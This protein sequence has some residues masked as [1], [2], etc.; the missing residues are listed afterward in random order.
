MTKLTKKDMEKV[1]KECDNPMEEAVILLMFSSGLCP[2]EIVKLK[3]S[4]FTNSITEYLMQDIME[5]QIIGTWHIQSSNTCLEYHVLNSPESSRAIFKYLNLRKPNSPISPLDP[6]F[7]N[8]KGNPLSIEDITSIL[9]KLNG[10]AGFYFRKLTAHNIKKYFNWV[11]ESVYGKHD[12]V[13]QYI[14]GNAT[15]PHSAKELKEVSHRLKYFYA[16][17]LPALTLYYDEEPDENIDLG[18]LWGL[19]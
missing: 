16:E 13:I 3:I 17:F 7:I 9:D 11:F 8:A 19:K 10:K 1:I 2:C 18:I 5:E 4:D 6:L 12:E 15:N 14:S